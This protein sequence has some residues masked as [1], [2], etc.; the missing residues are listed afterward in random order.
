M[1]QRLRRFRERFL[2]ERDPAPSAG[3]WP[4]RALQRQDRRPVF[5]NVTGLKLD[6]PVMALFAVLGAGVTLKADADELPLA[7]LPAV[8]FVEMAPG[9]AI[10]AIAVGL[11]NRR[12]RLSH[13]STIHVVLYFVKN[14]D[15]DRP[16]SGLT[17][18]L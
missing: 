9:P 8:E 14:Q 18:P 11:G 17:L 1:F 13:S 7:T 16:L 12:D 4:L 5:P 15:I 2:I 10:R 6:P 3:L